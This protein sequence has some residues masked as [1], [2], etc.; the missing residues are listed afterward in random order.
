MQTNT[1]VKNLREEVSMT[2]Q[3]RLRTR[4]LEKFFALK[5]NKTD[6]GRAEAIGVNP[7]TYSRVTRGLTAPG[8][9]FIAGTL[10]AFPEMS[11]EDLFEVATDP[12][13]VSA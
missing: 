5:G 4:Q 6:T 12:E 2:A 1:Q 9:R 3:V 10:A 7:A 13:Q 11:F 8:E